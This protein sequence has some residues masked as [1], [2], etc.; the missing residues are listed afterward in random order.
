MK[1]MWADYRLTIVKNVPILEDGSI[2]IST[3]I[4]LTF[5]LVCSARLTLHIYDRIGRSLCNQNINP[6]IE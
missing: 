5:Q 2:T 3:T 6:R 1:K 4:F